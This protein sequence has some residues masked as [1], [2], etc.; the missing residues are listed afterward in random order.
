M[1]SENDVQEPYT[2]NGLLHYVCHVLYKNHIF[3][4]LPSKF[5]LDS[6]HHIVSDQEANYGC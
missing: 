2:C 4:C 3:I 1:N 5:I 6:K